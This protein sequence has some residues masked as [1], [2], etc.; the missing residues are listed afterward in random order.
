[1][2]APTLAEPQ[3]LS[4][5]AAVRMVAAREIRTRVRSRA[6]VIGNGI[7]LALI[8]GSLMVTAALR[9]DPGKPVKVGVVGQASQLGDALK[10]AGEGL[11]TKVDLR[12]IASAEAARTAL[13]ED[14]VKVVLL[15]EGQGF[16]AQANKRLS[17][18]LQA[19]LTSAVQ[20]RAVTEAL[21]KEGVDP[22]L[23]A[24]AAQ[25]A[26]LSVRFLEPPK[27]DAD[28]RTALAL[29][30]AVLLYIQLIG[31]GGAVAVAVVEE[32]TSRLVELLL[33]AIKPVQLLVGKVV[34]IG[35]VGLI[36]LTAQGAVGLGA[37][38]ATGVLD[39]TS[40]V[41]LTFV[42]T[43]GWYV[44][45]YLFFGVLY[46]AAGSLVS[47]Q[48]EV[49]SATA[50][51]SVLV[52]AMFTVAQFSASDPTG[53]L[54]N[55]MSWIPPFSAILMPLRIAAGV[56][57]PEQVI[58]T[59]LLMLVTTSVLAVLAG[60]VYQTAILRSGKGFRLKGLRRR[61]PATAS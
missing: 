32:K 45:G 51:L 58:G 43:L 1:M 61:K 14:D 38:A 50:P 57:T 3:A 22:L 19:V 41:V 15:R 12:P 7:F 9:D 2:S 5:A 8:V 59:V 48:E 20:Q 11:K 18:T 47:K 13:V 10:A 16:V 6:F 55:T 4:T 27:K 54:S 21:R 49:T 42:S 39:L 40:T 30:V 44:L 25:K 33:A 37:A 36:Q 52:I 34:G 29:A 26:T 24:G 60:K 56:T 31:N 35:I 46:A 53:S 28:Q 17:P 23:L